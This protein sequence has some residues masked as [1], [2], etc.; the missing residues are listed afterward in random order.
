MS[1]PAT[2]R[3]REDSRLN[4]YAMYPAA[5]RGLIA[6]L[7]SAYYYDKVKTEEKTQRVEYLS[8]CRHLCFIS[9]RI[10]RLMQEEQGCA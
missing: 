7:S 8:L 5:S 1:F 9:G 4:M 2:I 10:H 6:K 3:S